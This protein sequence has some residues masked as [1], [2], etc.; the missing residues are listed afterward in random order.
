MT[1]NNIEIK[2]IKGLRAGMDSTQINKLKMKIDSNKS[3][4]EV[5]KIV[6]DL[7]DV[8]KKK[9]FMDELLPYKLNLVKDAVDERDYKFDSSDFNLYESSNA[10]DWTST[11]SP[12]KD[13]GQL[14]SCVAFATAA[15]KEWQEQQEQEQELKEGKKYRRKSKYYDYSEQWIYYNCKKIDPWPNDEGTSLRYA[16]RVL[17][18][19]GVPCEKGW[20][21]NDK[22]KGEPEKWAKMVS[23][24]ALID[25]YYRLKGL[26]DLKLALQAGPVIAGIY[27]FREMFTVGKDGVISYPNNPQ[28]IYGGH[29]IC[30]VGFDDSKKLVKFKNSW[31]TSWGQNGYGYLPYSYI[32]NF[33]LD[34]W[35][36]KDIKVTKKHFNESMDNEL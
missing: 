5:K 33:M 16:M 22:V 2:N 11:M 29:A 31:S 6:K 10:I 20:K 12:V 17:N 7:K 15:M 9:I 3:K 21:Y 34:A 19:I 30:I 1:M 32:N 14:G 26:D 8:M 18:K 4:K 13:Q 25:S 24:W 28:E 23:R 27:C 36:A 35:A